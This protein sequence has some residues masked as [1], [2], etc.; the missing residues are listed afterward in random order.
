LDPEVTETVTAR[1]GPMAAPIPIAAG[2]A[3]AAVPPFT[4]AFVGAGRAG[5]AL[6]VALAAAGHSIVAISGRDPER[7][8]AL[9]ERVGARPVSTALAAIRAADLTFLTVPDSA[10]T[11]VAASVAATGAGLRRHGVV[12]C[13]AGLG[14]AAV[15]ALRATGAAVGCLHPL[16]A[17]A[18]VESAPLLSG[19]LM[20]VDADPVLQAPLQHLT[21]DLGGRAVTL[22]PGA[23]ALYHAAAVLAGNAPLALV[24]AATE[25]LVAA[26]LD[27]PTAEQGLLALMEGALANARRAGPGEALTGPVARGDAATVARHLAALRD[28]PDADALYRAVSREIVRLAGVEGREQISD[29]LNGHRVGGTGLRA[30]RR[31]GAGG[32][33][34]AAEPRARHASQG[35]PTAVPQRSTRPVPPNMTEDQTCP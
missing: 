11:P 26:G 8:A 31:L 12:H 22:P 7:A 3:A 18:G 4:V 17:L 35:V 25:L 1:D 2:L 16:Q 10:V 27:P 33:C 28:H 15:A 20:V 24:S 32:S 9:A 21:R 29:M 5:G 34:N 30:E 23:R 19:A 14:I 13:S 6:A